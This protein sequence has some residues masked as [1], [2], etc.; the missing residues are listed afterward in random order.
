MHEHTLQHMIERQMRASRRF[1]EKKKKKAYTSTCCVYVRM[2]NTHRHTLS[3]H[4]IKV[5]YNIMKMKSSTSSRLLEASLSQKIRIQNSTPER[6]GRRNISGGGGR[7][8]GCKKTNKERGGGD[9]GRKNG[10]ARPLHDQEMNAS[11]AINYIRIKILSLLI[12]IYTESI[13]SILCR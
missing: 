5:K 3:A 9:K 11:I 2:L 8:G 1:R 13:A 10:Y 12:P 4:T 7:W 6:R